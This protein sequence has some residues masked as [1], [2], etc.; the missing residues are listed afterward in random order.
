M[1]TDQGRC[2][3][4]EGP[5]GDGA[6]AFGKTVS[7]GRGFIREKTVA[8]VEIEQP[9]LSWNTTLQ[10]LF[11]IGCEL[12]PVAQC[13]T[14]TLFRR[15]QTFGCHTGETQDPDG[16]IFQ[17]RGAQGLRGCAENVH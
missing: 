12:F 17:T 5:D 10:R 6:V 15:R 1:E 16:I 4:C 14:F 3:Q 7:L 13:R 2:V 8:V 9:E 11:E